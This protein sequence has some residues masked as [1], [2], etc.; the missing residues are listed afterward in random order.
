MYI[1]HIF[2]QI[3]FLQKPYVLGGKQQ[4]LPFWQKSLTCNI[5]FSTVAFAQ[6]S[7]FLYIHWSFCAAWGWMAF[8]GWVEWRTVLGRRNLLISISIPSTALFY[9]TKPHWNSGCNGQN[10]NNLS[11]KASLLVLH[12]TDFHFWPTTRFVSRAEKKS[13]SRQLGRN[14]T[15]FEKKKKKKFLWWISITFFFSLHFRKVPPH[16]CS[17]YFLLGFMCG[18]YLL[19]LSCDTEI[20]LETMVY[21]TLACS[22]GDAITV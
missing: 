21:S 9:P 15:S 16:S 5:C 19:W 8:A 1:S 7:F 3:Q 13:G 4:T 10:G 20:L 6:C 18:E 11:F 14:V 12:K 2:S 22:L 17:G